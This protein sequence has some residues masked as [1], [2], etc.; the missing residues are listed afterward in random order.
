MEKIEENK[1]V[2]GIAAAC[3]VAVF[4]VYKFWPSAAAKDENDISDISQDYIDAW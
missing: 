2:I 1:K 4:A 3:A